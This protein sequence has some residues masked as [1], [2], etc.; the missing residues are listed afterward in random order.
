MTV[1]KILRMSEGSE[2]FRAEMRPCLCLHLYLV[3][4]GLPLLPT[5][6]I[7]A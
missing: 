2:G 3:F 1:L 5:P 7:L 4:Y 6:L